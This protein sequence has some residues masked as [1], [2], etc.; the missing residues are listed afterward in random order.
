[1]SETTRH[2]SS[3]PRPEFEEFGAFYQS[4]LDEHADP[5]NRKYHFIGTGIA[6]CVLLHMLCTAKWWLAPM[7]P[8]AMY[9]FS[10]FGHRYVQGNR[11]DTWRRP[12]YSFAA[13][14]R[15]FMDI[16]AHKIHID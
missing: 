7:V 1:M 11:P 3:P 15:M 5:R 13:H 10:W 8:A 9:G 2:Q 14:I 4:F 16:I 12:L 6:L